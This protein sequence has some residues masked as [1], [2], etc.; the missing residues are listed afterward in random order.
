MKQ[1]SSHRSIRH[2]DDR[3]RAAAF[4]ALETRVLFAGGG[5]GGGADPIFPDQYEPNNSFAAAT[6]PGTTNTA[7]RVSLTI[8]KPTVGSDVDWFKFTA[9]SSG[10]VGVELDFIHLSG[11]LQ[12]TGYDSAQA[13]I[14]FSNSST[15]TNNLESF[16][17]N[18]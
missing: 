3:L 7:E 12:L 8:H 16:T 15:S 1:I 6:N 17:L 9:A 14:A 13:Q 2:R 4:E 11:N 10:T 5:D 18:L